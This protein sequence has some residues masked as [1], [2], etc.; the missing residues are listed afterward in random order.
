MRNSQLALELMGQTGLRQEGGAE[1]VLR[2]AKLLQ[3]YEG[4]NQL[5]RLNLFK[6]LIR[7]TGELPLP[8]PSGDPIPWS[9]GSFPGAVPG[10]LSGLENL[11]T[12]FAAK[13]LLGSA[14]AAERGP[15][16]RLR[17][18]VLDKARQAGFWE[19]FLPEAQGGAGLTALC[20]L[21][22]R[23][24]QADASLGGI[25]FT[26]ALAQALVMAAEGEEGVSG[27][28][29]DS[30]CLFLIREPRRHH[31]FPEASFLNAYSLT[32]RVD[33][34]VVATLRSGRYPRPGS[35]RGGYSPSRGFADPGMRK[36]PPVLTLGLAACPAVDATLAEVRGRLLGERDQGRRYLHSVWGPMHAAAGAMN[37]GIM[38][39][40]CQAALDYARTRRQGGQRILD[41]G[42]V[43]M[44]LAGMLAKTDAAALAVSSA[45]R[46]LEEGRPDGCRQA[47]GAALQVHE[48]ACGVV[49]DG[50]QV[51]GGYG[52]MR[53]Y[54]Q[55]RR[56]RDA[57]QVQALLGAAPLRKLALL[58]ALP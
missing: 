26:N 23:L 41:W 8:S 22:E 42:E 30:D 40:A 7:H 16:D 1:K 50:V 17:G 34:L 9:P 24:C 11:A 27:L 18:H 45:C 44:V 29:G 31:G 5:N 58:G 55:E 43:G 12:S 21:L 46:C 51:L 56:F 33:L 28:R 25:L 4:T 15:S 14:A 3:I 10:D 48:L 13:E 49:D 19:V 2:D 47:V 36:S 32:G 35:L 54:G 6:C 37:A 38:R 20:L 39:G 52:Y 57:R 53:D